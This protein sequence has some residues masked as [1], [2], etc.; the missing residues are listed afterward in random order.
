VCG[1]NNHPFTQVELGSNTFVQNMKHNGID[2]LSLEITSKLLTD[3]V[4]TDD[5]IIREMRFD[6]GALSGPRW[7]NHENETVKWY[8]IVFH[9]TNIHELANRVNHC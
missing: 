5:F 3:C 1:V 2:I 9:N 8:L 7:T 4:A 6:S